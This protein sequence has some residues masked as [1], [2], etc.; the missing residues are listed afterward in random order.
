MM[1]I[2]DNLPPDMHNGIL[3]FKVGMNKV[4]D[5]HPLTFQMNALED[6]EE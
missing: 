5:P 3:E 1:P 6:E 4:W 2:P